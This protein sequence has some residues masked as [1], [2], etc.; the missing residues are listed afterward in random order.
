MNSLL[1]LINAKYHQIIMVERR[2]Y[3]IEDLEKKIVDVYREYEESGDYEELIEFFDSLDKPNNS[4]RALFSK[5]YTHN[6]GHILSVI[7]V[8]KLS[9]KKRVSKSTLTAFF[10][11]IVNK[12][13]EY[14]IIVVD[15]LLSTGATAGLTALSN[16]RFIQVFHQNE[17]YFDPTEHVDV[18]IHSKLS[19]EEAAKKIKELRVGPGSSTL[20]IQSS[21]PIVKYNGWRPGDFIKVIRNDLNLKVLARK[22]INY[23]KVV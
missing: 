4:Y 16:N 3:I 12:D 17:L 9:G 10:N 19:K 20:L 2:G 13:R 21:D 8:S 7:Y 6:D 23:R 5:D 11:Y 15:S 1:S 22:T 14:G 18:S